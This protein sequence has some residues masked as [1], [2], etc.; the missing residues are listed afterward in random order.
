MSLAD[1]IF[2]HGLRAALL[3]VVSVALIAGCSRDDG[4]DSIDDDV[5]VLDTLNGAVNNLP[6][7]ILVFIE[8]LIALGLTDLLNNDLFGVLSGHAAE[9]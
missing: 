3:A 6:D 9:V 4:L 7:A 2:T 8:L 5:A 1:R